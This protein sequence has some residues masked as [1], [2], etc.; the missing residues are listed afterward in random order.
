MHINVYSSCLS[1]VITLQIILRIDFCRQFGL[2]LFR[3]RC[4]TANT[5]HNEATKYFFSLS[6]NSAN[7]KKVLIIIFFCSWKQFC[8]KITLHL[9]VSLQKKLHSEQWLSVCSGS[10]THNLPVASTEWITGKRKCSSL[11]LISKQQGIWLS[12]LPW[13]LFCSLR[14]IL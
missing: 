14:R 12:L 7:R 5:A 1:F 3:L 10:W 2:A 13:A 6:V 8:S 4:H 9:L 11:Y